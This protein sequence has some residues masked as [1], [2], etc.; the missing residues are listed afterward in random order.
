MTNIKQNIKCDQLTINSWKS[1]WLEIKDTLNKSFG[2]GLRNSS[3]RRFLLFRYYYLLTVVQYMR[4]K[5][6]M[7]LD[8]L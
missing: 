3:I 4:Q 2:Y 8:S 6:V 5:L 1:I 7:Y